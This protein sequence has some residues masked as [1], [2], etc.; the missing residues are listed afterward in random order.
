MQIAA[1]C[2]A[3]VCFVATPILLFVMLQTLAFDSNFL[4]IVMLGFIAAAI[5]SG[6]EYLASMNAS[7]LTSA[8][9]LTKIVESQSKRA[10]K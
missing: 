2:V 5:D 3:A 10:V 8:Q 4:L 1:R 7:C 9:A 6:L